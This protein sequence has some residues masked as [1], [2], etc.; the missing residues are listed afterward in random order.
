MRQNLGIFFRAL[1]VSL[2][3]V[4]LPLAASG[5]GPKVPLIELKAS[6]SAAEM[7]RGTS[8][9][10]DGAADKMMMPNPFTYTYVAGEKLSD[11]AGNGKV[12]KVVIDGDP[13]AVLTKLAKV[14]G[15]TGNVFEPEYSQP[16][17]PTFQ[18]G[19]KDGSGPSATINGSGTGNWWFNDPSAYPSP[20]C[21]ESATSDDGSEYCT[22]YEEQ[23]STPGLIP[24]KDK[25]IAAAV[26][27]FNATGLKVAAS[28]IRVDISEWGASASA[29]LKID[30]ADT[31]IEWY[32]SWGM[33]GK[34]GSVS[35][36]SVRFEAK[37]NLDTISARAA[38]ARMSDWRYSGQIA[39]SLWNKYAPP[40]RAGEPD[41]IAYDAPLEVGESTEPEV[42]PEA[43][44]EPIVV[45]VDEAH[46]VSVLIWDK[47][48][49]AWLVPG[50]VL[51][52]DQ[53]WLTP[54][55]SLE[56]GVVALPDPVA[57]EP[58]L[59]DSVS[60]EPGQSGEVSPM[61]K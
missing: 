21:L 54:V 25:V 4:L 8:L 30:G 61:V 57:I 23:K 32:M 58:R 60:T 18:I 48:G 22:T 53:G 3:L 59:D 36:N 38:V 16:E 11:E 10:A 42:T 28:D 39:S 44:P 33:N 12:Y 31:P 1:G 17:Y 46:A 14:F 5:F 55:F 20:K 2:I 9:A 29:S 40:V 37:G 47:N 34:L 24:S 19:S 45:T 15:I 13:K 26:E 56:D 7:G 35:G 6:G 41:M 52:G 50:Y 51:I 49:N 43:T 27:M